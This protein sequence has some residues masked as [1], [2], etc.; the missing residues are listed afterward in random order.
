[1]SISNVNLIRNAL[2]LIKV[3]RVGE[4]AESEHSELGIQKLN[5]LLADWEADGVNL[6]YFPQTIDDLGNDCPIPNDAELAVTYYL[7][8]ALAPH[9]GKQ[10][11]PAMMALGQKY[12]ERLTRDAVSEKLV[13]ARL[14]LPAAEAGTGVYD[15]THG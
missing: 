7:A 13:E 10:V 12:Y 6:Q 1:M 3:L 14:A 8:F 5:A 15:I 4:A 9:Y 11:D 2:S